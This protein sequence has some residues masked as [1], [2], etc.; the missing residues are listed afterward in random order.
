RNI[1]TLEGLGTRQTPHPVQQAFIDEQAAQCGYCLNGMIM[2]AKALLDRNPN[3]SEAEVRSELSGNLC[4]CGTHI[5]I[6]RAV[7][8]AA[9]QMP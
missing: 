3:P 4:R 1:V 6:L 5:E 9:R 2:T 7:L 8:R